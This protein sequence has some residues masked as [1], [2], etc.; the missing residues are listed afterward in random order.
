[1]NSMIIA[2]IYLFTIISIIII[3]QLLIPILKK[4]WGSH[5]HQGALKQI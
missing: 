1:M 5:V 4:R 3:I 2:A